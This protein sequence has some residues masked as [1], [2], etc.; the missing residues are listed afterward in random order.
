MLINSTKFYSCSK[1]KYS[2]NTNTPLWDS[3]QIYDEK[4]RM[5]D[6]SGYLKLSNGYLP[7][8]NDIEELG[9]SKN[10][11]FGLTLL[12]LLIFICLIIGGITILFI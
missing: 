11:W 4:L 2:I 12:H 8:N 10:I 6:G 3:G 9:F 1:S 7:I 5:K